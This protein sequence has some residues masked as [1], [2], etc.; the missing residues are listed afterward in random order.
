MRQELLRDLEEYGEQTDEEVQARIDVLIQRESDRQSLPLRLREELYTG[1]FNSVRKLDILQELSD[2][3]D[4]TEIMINGWQNIFY[5]KKGKIRRWDRQ[6][7]TPERLEDVIQEI[8][9]SCNR[10]V[11]EQRPVADAR[12]EN[13]SR[14][15]IVL[16]PV[17]LEGPILTIR[18]FPDRPITMDTLIAL[19]SL[20][21]EAAEFLRG[22]VEARYSLLIGGGTSTG[23]TTFLNALSSYIPTDERVITIED[24]AELQL[25]GLPNLVRL[26]AR[27][28]AMEGAAAVTIR[29]L[30]RT[31]LRMRPDR[32]IIGEVRGAE[33]GDFLVCLNTGHDG[34]MG[35]A[36]A[37]SVR[38]MVS[39]LEMMVLMGMDL[40]VSVIRRQIAAGV[41]ILVHL[42]RDASGVRRVEEI[43]EITGMKGDE[44][45]M[46]TLFQRDRNGA[47]VRTGELHSVTKWE[48][49]HSAAEAE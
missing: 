20:T 8:A 42:S 5:E 19:G 21:R 22:L 3:P 30:I 16:P 23:K 29:D 25:Q 48:R 33:A 35:S 39:R 38:E 26:E 6:F 43:A 18:R 46:H 13:G 17:S 27:E 49:T 28:A 41:E 15:N 44:I 40:S 47:L 4:V 45:L 37:N 2:D 1:L 7:S 9:G 24:N 32:V 34:S 10:V 31:A 12:L 36:H 11:N 14:V